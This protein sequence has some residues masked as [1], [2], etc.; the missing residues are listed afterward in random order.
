MKYSRLLQILVQ[1]SGV[2]GVS[3]VLLPEVLAVGVELTSVRHGDSVRFEF[4]SNIQ[5]RIFDIQNSSSIEFVSN[6]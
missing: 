1:I 4:E 6:I 5:K 2:S 3:G